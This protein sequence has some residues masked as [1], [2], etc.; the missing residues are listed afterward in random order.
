MMELVLIL[1]TVVLI[2]ACG[3]FVAAEFAL[4][5]VNR[6]TVERLAGK[7][8]GP[9]SGVLSALRT[10]S[11][12]LSSAQVGITITNLAIG[13]LAEPVIARL[14]SPAILAIGLPEAS[15]SGISIACGLIIATALTMVF[16]ELVPKNLA[17]ARPLATARFVQRPLLFFTAVMKFPIRVLNGSANWILHRFGVE[18]K[19]ELASARSADELL[20]LV[21]RSAA[22]GTLAQDTATMLERSLGF[23]DLTALDVMTPRVRVK[24][25]QADTPV[26]EALLLAASSGLSRYPVYGKNLD[27]I[28]GVMHVKHAFG[29]PHE[30]RRTTAVARVMR[31]AML[32]PSSI[33]LMKLLETLRRRGLQ[34]VVAIDEFGGMDGIV[35]MEDVLEE[36]VGDV[37]D[38]HDQSRGTHIRPHGTDSWIVS[39]LLRPDEISDELGIF[40]AE[41]DDVETLGGLFMH[42]S[43]DVPHKGDRVTL[44]A[45]DRDGTNLAVTLKVERMDSNRIDRLLLTSKSVEGEQ[46]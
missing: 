5:A 30:Q 33:G 9:A 16:G 46:T 18:P 4:L 42:E 35:T 26:S 44:P 24:A 29:I 21:R 2:L 12:Q 38:E 37:R 13:F 27:D 45:I 8:D 11:T 31:P 32:V 17:I 14:L 1:V 23:T 36:L 25:V 7:G 19:E 43:S 20:S 40:L 15:V 3:I 34:L 10:L 28:V 22:K 41:E 39:G 6:Q